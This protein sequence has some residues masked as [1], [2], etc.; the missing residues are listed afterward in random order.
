METG[1][2]ALNRPALSTPAAAARG[3][4]GVGASAFLSILSAQPEAVAKAKVGSAAAAGGTARPE[5]PIAETADPTTRAGRAPGVPAPGPIEDRIVGIA[6]KDSGTIELTPED[7][8]A[9]EAGSDRPPAMKRDRAAPPPAKDSPPAMAVRAEAPGGGDG[10]DG[11]RHGGPRALALPGEI[12][13][14]IP[15]P[16]RTATPVDARFADLPRTLAPSETATIPRPAI[17]D[18]ELLLPASGAPTDAAIVRNALTGNEG[19]GVIAAPEKRSALDPASPGRMTAAD[20]VAMPGAPDGPGPAIVPDM[21]GPLVPSAPTGAPAIEPYGAAIIAAAFSPDAAPPPA[22]DPRPLEAATAPRRSDET[23]GSPA[24]PGAAAVRV[25][26]PPAIGDAR[27]PSAGDAEPPIVTGASRPASPDTLSAEWRPA[28]ETGAPAPAPGRALGIA[29]RG[30]VA[31]AA[32]SGTILPEP[33]VGP[34]GGLTRAEAA[35]AAAEPDAPIDKLAAGTG[36]SA[37]KTSGEVE[38]RGTPVAAE[39]PARAE[40]VRSAPGAEAP[41]D[42]APVRRE[43]S[44]PAAGTDPGRLA[45]RIADNA[46]FDAAVRVAPPAAGEIV[47]ASP[48]SDGRPAAVTPSLSAV[49]TSATAPAALTAAAAVAAPEATAAESR[50]ARPD[51]RRATGLSLPA[52]RREAAEALP[53]TESESASPRT[54]SP[55]AV[56]EAAARASAAAGAGSPKAQDAAPVPAAITLAAAGPAPASGGAPGPDGQTAEFRIPLAREATAH[57][58]AAAPMMVLRVQARDGAR[59]IEI[60]LD[61]ADLGEVNVKLETGKDG[62]LKAVLSAENR[63]SFDLLKRES[64]ALESALREAGVELGDDAITFTLNERGPGQGDA[65]RRELAYGDSAAR[66]DAAASEDIVAAAP[67]RWRSGILDISA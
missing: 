41:P 11:E 26:E 2:A 17:A 34:A 55:F 28:V 4:K 38:M 31:L 61:P 60:R 57:A 42:D 37:A 6:A 67:V 47:T 40:S 9:E 52:A 35:P 63:D 44:Q 48:A 29:E 12:P 30:S 22:R 64:G 53:R 15:A 14:P 56:A 43:P 1:A 10:A 49:L 39:G 58:A 32:T 46:A 24:R 51:A 62:R 3:G 5:K 25:P 45:A 13:T 8:P 65:D 54:A 59:S 20:I 21:S 27:G 16:P 18:E 23:P 36:W 50:T 7:E 66:R 33:A 19:A